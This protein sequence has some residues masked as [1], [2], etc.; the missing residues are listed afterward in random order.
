MKLKKT[1]A[2]LTA[3]CFLLSFFYAISPTLATPDFDP[4][5]IISDAD[6]TDSNSTTQESI[7]E[8]LKNQNGALASYVDPITRRRASEII[9]QSAGTY[10]I[11]PRVLIALIQKEQSLV[12]DSAPKETQYR[13]AAGFALC[14]DCDPFDPRVAIFGGFTNQVDRATWRFRWY[15]DELKNGTTDWLK[16]PGQTYSIDGYNVTPVNIATA[17]L[18]NYTPHYHGNYNF[19]RI[20]NAWFAKI[21][22]DGSL[23]RQAGTNETWLI[24][25]GKKRRFISMS[26][27]RSRFDTNK[28]ID[29]GK[30]ELE[31]YEISNPIKFAQYSLLRSPR[32]T[33]FLIVNDERRGIA[34]KDVFRTIGF[35]WE[36][37][38]DVSF[39]ELNNYSEGRPITLKSIYPLGALLQ[40]KK[41]GGVYYV[42]N[43]VK[44]A[45]Y[46]KE[47]LNSNF[48]TRKLTAVTPEELEKYP[49][50]LPIQFNDGELVMANN[51]DIIYI[52]SND[53]RRP[54]AS[55][56][57][58]DK[59]GYKWENVI[60]TN[61]KALEI[62]PLG[63][64]I[65]YISEQIPI[66]NQ[67]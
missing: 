36:E 63:S 6:L 19:W 31:R 1:I 5:F 2:K 47:I 34:S 52:I 9:W 65:T 66:D 48:K 56:E 50:G 55:R 16:R 21:Y 29:V 62:H 44:H 59:L 26:A 53:E 30:D 14:D 25:G 51:S 46:S 12:T 43:G 67:L 38:E 35:N 41:T 20:W 37:V 23:L 18:Y 64:P 13:W 17:A 24:Q 58:F 45:I 60:K 22:P 40:N 33:V 39:A 57:I 42:E 4:N 28:I 15:I 27:L 49:T 32:G 7:Q 11:N 10:G 54:F 61:D 8:F 3:I